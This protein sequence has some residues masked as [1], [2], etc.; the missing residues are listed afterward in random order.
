M[1]EFFAAGQWCRPDYF[2]QQAASVTQRDDAY[3]HNFDWQSLGLL[4]VKHPEHGT[5]GIVP[6]YYPWREVA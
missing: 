2:A 1:I 5:I 3:W 4:R 6:K